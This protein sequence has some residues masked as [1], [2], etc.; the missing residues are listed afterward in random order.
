M[1]KKNFKPKS[2]EEKQKEI[3]DLT[4]S[5]HDRVNSYF[6]TPEQMKEYLAFNSRFYQYSRRNA[7]L[8]DFQFPGA[9]AVGSFAFWKKNG[10]SVNKGEKGIKIL[11]PTPFEY[12][13]RDGSDLKIPINK[14]TREEQEKIRNKEIT[15]RK[16]MFFTV[17]HVFD[18]SQTNAK[19]KDLPDIFPNRWLEGHVEDYSL[20]RSALEKVAETNGIKIVEPY[21][22]LGVAKGV[23]YTDR[24]EVALNPRNSELQDVKTLIH[25]LAHATLH[26]TETRDNYTYNERE[27]QAEMTAFTVCS[28]LGIDTS[29]YSLQYIH[30]YAKDES[31]FNDK[32]KLLEEVNKTSCG[33]IEIIEKEFVANRVIEDEKEKDENKEAGPMVN[34]EWSDVKGL[35]PN[36]S[37]SVKEM[38]DF[39]LNAN[40]ELQTSDKDRFELSTK[41]KVVDADGNSF[42]FSNF[43]MHKIE[44]EQIFSSLIQQI[45]VE[46]PELYHKIA[47]QQNITSADLGFNKENENPLKLLISKFENYQ[48]LLHEEK[49]GGL[50]EDITVNRLI[51]E[52]DYFE[53]K[54]ELIKTGKL[55]EE[56]IRNFETK[57]TSKKNPLSHQ[58]DP[59]KT[60][61]DIPKQINRKIAQ[62]LDR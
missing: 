8:I 15:I 17:T 58:D 43:H 1:A 3:K 24:K 21:E 53:S 57:I 30:H 27:F 42:S 41:F 13:M 29:E 60:H 61:Q 7:A 12:F 18:V 62:E 34:V 22:E 28:Y 35:D 33:F 40:K 59:Q 14:A 50:N 55:T 23:S 46:N 6:M 56:E 5:L 32:L 11:K 16:D 4:N 31:Q 45:H 54:S 19:A 49:S 39:L 47:E 25:E 37:M 26:T 10:F 51:A 48:R 52:N 2:F 9:T 44:E 20:V 38:N 36:T